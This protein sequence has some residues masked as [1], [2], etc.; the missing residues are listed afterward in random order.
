[1]DKKIAE[2]TADKKEYDDCMSLGYTKY[3]SKLAATKQ[4]SSSCVYTLNEVTHDADKWRELF[5]SSCPGGFPNSDKKY[6]CTASDA[7]N[8]CSQKCEAFYASS[9]VT[10]IPDPNPDPKPN[11]EP[12]PN[13]DP[14]PVENV[15]TPIFDAPNNGVKYST[16]MQSMNVTCYM[17]GNSCPNG[18]D[19][20]VVFKP[21]HNSSSSVRKNAYLAGTRFNP[22]ACK[23]GQACTIC[24]SSNAADCVTTIFRGS[25]PPVGRF[26]VT[27]GFLLR[28]C[29]SDDLLNLRSDMPAGIQSI[30]KSVRKISTSYQTKINCIDNPTHPTCKSFMTE[31]EKKKND[32]LSKY[33][34]CLRLGETKYNA[35]KSESEQ[36]IYG[37][38]YRKLST[39]HGVNQTLWHD[40]MPG[41]CPKDS[42]VSPNGLDCCSANEVVSA[43]SGDCGVFFK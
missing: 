16:N 2:R 1:M 28:H 14:D 31:Q 20:H 19:S 33:E 29:Y 41:A 11:P 9:V 40:L 24:F 25:G 6:C 38:A 23:D 13:T 26:D 34:E 18:C 5:P 42:F 17:D 12:D 36:R 32:D 27:P 10:P 22:Q 7:V 21:D 43:C 30:C 15:N 35:G 8:A 39:K 37:C 3:N 4:R